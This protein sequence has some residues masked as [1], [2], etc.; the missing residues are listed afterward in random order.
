[1]KKGTTVGRTW[2]WASLILTSL[3]GLSLTGLAQDSTWMRKSD[4]PISASGIGTGIIDGKIYV[5]SGWHTPGAPIRAFQVYDT[6]ADTWTVKPDLPS[7]IFAEPVYYSS[8]CVI[9]NEVYVLGG[10]QDG[11]SSY[12]NPAETL[13]VFNLASNSWVLRAKMPTARGWI[14]SVVLNNK[15]YAMGGLAKSGT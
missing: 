3:L 4:M 9:K 14:A 8:V 1:M 10:F 6:Q 15:I 7:S 11:N 12:L 5:I 2:L 13:K